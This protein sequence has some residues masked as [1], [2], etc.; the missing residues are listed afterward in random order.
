[1][2]FRFSPEEEA[3]RSEVQEFLD[4]E[5]PRERCLGSLPGGEKMPV[6]GPLA[7]GYMPSAEAE[8]KLGA[9]GWLSL[10][11]PT[12][13]GGGG[14]PLVYQTIVD[15]ELAY[16]NIP[17]SESIGR[18]IV[19][20]TLIALGSEDLK[21][22]FLP[23]LAR[24]EID[25]CLGYT[26]PEA[27]SDLASLTTRAVVEGD[28]Y[29]INGSKVYTSGADISHYCW[30]LATTDPG[31]AK[32][33]GL[34]L[35]IVPMDAPGIS[36]RPLLNLMNLG[37]FNEVVLEDVLV[38]RRGLVGMKNEGWHIVTAAL[39]SERLALYHCR[40][41]FRVF[42]SLLEYA[43]RVQRDGQPLSQ[44]PLLRQ[45]LAQLATDFQVARL[46]TYRAAWLRGTGQALS[47]ESA[48]VKLFNTEL[49]QRL[50]QVA[51]EILGLHGGLMGD[52]ARTVL[53]GMVSHNYLSVVQD[54]I[55]AGTSEVQR[56]IIA[57]RGLDLPRG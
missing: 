37:W 55:G 1:M 12:E 3:F 11:W 22:E 57:R 24:G 27:G 48:M 26:E 40:S 33:K 13:Y 38:S 14:K 34:S 15:E 46:L 4:R 10:S 29:V 7:P 54:T 9:K 41:Q 21:R 32:H 39:S 45:K 19:A 2:D 25:F 18:T 49:A 28:D 50:Y 6:P 36:V 8:R 16:R 30:L 20:P 47:Y 5:W 52:S 31:V 53:A 56:D 35:F 42:E 44:Q 23:R 51:M 43:K 17:G